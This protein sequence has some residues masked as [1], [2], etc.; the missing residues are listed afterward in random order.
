[1]GRN[2]GK[3]F[4]T[5]Y[6]L[7]KYPEVAEMGINPLLH[8]ALFGEALGYSRRPK[9]MDASKPELRYVNAA[10]A[11]IFNLGF[12]EKPIKE[13]EYI[14]SNTSHNNVRF[15]AK[16]VL[17]EVN[18]RKHN[19][20][21]YKKA[22]EFLLAARSDVKN[23]ARQKRIATLEL[24]CTGLLG[25][26][27]AG[28]TIFDRAV[29]SGEIS[30]DL[31][32]AYTSCKQSINEKIA[33]LNTVFEWNNLC[34]IGVLQDEYYRLFDRL[35][36][37]Q[38][39][40]F[41][42]TGPMVSILVAA[43]DA[44]DSLPTALRSLQEQTWQNLEVIIIHNG[45][46]DHMVASNAMQSIAERDP[47]IKIIRNH[48]NSGLPQ[49]WNNGLGI[50]TG[51]FVAL[52]NANVWAHP[53]K[54]ELQVRNLLAN[55]DTIACTTDNVFCTSELSISHWSDR[56]QIQLD[57]ASSMM[58]RREKVLAH[59]GYWDTVKF[60]ANEEFIERILCVWG[61][62][63]V[64]NIKK[65]F[66]SLTSDDHD[67]PHKDDVIPKGGE[68]YFGA[69]RQYREARQFFHHKSP[70]LLKYSRTSRTRP[71]PVPRLLDTKLGAS[72][73]KKH[74]D[75]IITSDFRL[76]GGSS[77][78]NAQEIFCQSRHGI[79]TAIFPMYRYDVEHNID[80]PMTD[81]VWQQVCDGN[82]DILTYGEAASCDVLVIRY[83][84]VLNEY[85]KYIPS[86]EA[87]DIRIIVNQPPRSDYSPQ[88]IVRYELEKC[89]SNIRRAFGK[90]ATWH[91][92]G[93]LV[94]D[95]LTTHHAAELQHINLSDW[96]WSNIIDIAGW[97]RGKRKRLPSDRIRIGRHS[98]DHE[99]K[100]PDTRQEILCIYP[101][102]DDVEVHVLGGASVPSNLIGKTPNNWVVHEFGS[103]HPRNF[104]AEIDV[105]IYFAHSGWVESFGRTI[106][107]AMAVGVPVIIPEI[108]KPLFHDA[109][110]YACPED[111]MKKA[112]EIHHNPDYYQSQVDYALKYVRE[113]FSYDEHYR[114][115]QEVRRV[116]NGNT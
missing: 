6:Y 32:L 61:E 15:M 110:I 106:I 97:S 91:P 95:A 55:P 50:A 83:P 29:S 13:L 21:G 86:I 116:G 36:S 77:Q 26:V 1:M 92:I 47:R 10:R 20:E 19:K 4:D 25:D 2:P 63:A 112:R 84:P 7:E 111:A 18:I 59:I 39:A 43:V 51:E 35:C 57:D 17:A 53:Q 5:K 93:P 40:I 60:G 45:L 101:D 115:I 82:A 33:C 114:R 113:N 85:T 88:G 44:A 30:S 87:N 41:V 96:N 105:F 69:L 79:K 14:C 89:A 22:L 81:E 108:Y 104:L 64:N 99:H 49:A 76:F 28:N 34:K 78:S 65:G 31:M 9:Y 62:G 48:R 72:Q 70:E 109:A 58:F 8:Y 67:A 80:R 3:G 98:R 73:D 16:L 90:E 56:G 23:L 74:Y 66:L 38:E 52:H 94:R 107:E 27:E 37:K 24:L 100:W 11:K 42:E 46:S 75:V 71:F 54:I 103:I 12:V 102:S 68:S